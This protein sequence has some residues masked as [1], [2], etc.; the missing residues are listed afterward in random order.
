[1]S[2]KYSYK[3][4]PSGKT[5]KSLILILAQFSLLT[6]SFFRYFV[7]G[8]VNVY[9]FNQ[10]IVVGCT[11][12]HNGPA[13]FIKFKDYK[14]HTGGLSVSLF[15]H[16]SLHQTELNVTI[17]DTIF[18]NNSA[19]PEET[20]QR[21]PSQLFDQ[22]IFTG[23]GGALGLFFGNNISRVNAEVMN[24]LFE[25]NAALTFGGAAYV[26]FSSRSNHNVKIWNCR[27]R[28]NRSGFGAGALFVGFFDTGTSS[29]HSTVSIMET[30]FTENSAEQGGSCVVSSPGYQGVGWYM[31]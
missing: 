17:R 30:Q 18:H 3:I 24:C 15:R 12:E 14:G 29:I 22:F 28:R 1:M 10:L 21:S 8:A 5:N 25:N 9:N 20:A 7:Q 23:R 26:V 4:A 2:L 19:M 16:T 11:F 6:F 27:F 13:S 31:Q